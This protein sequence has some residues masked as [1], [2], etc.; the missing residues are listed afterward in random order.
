MFNAFTNYDVLNVVS[1]QDSK[2]K[3]W[4]QWYKDVYCF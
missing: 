1:T 2:L 3:E 4:K